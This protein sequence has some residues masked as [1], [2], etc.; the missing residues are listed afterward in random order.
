MTKTANTFTLPSAARTFYEA[1]AVAEDI[2]SQLEETAM[3]LIS[4]SR[5]STEET[6]K[7]GEHLERA[8]G[9]LPERTL[10]KWAVE[11]CGYT[12][13]HV[14]TQR[15]V[16]RNLAR[17]KDI[18]VELAV[19]PT[20]LGKLSAAEPEQIEQAIGF[21]AQHGRLRVADVAGIVAGAKQADDETRPE[22]GP[23]DA[24]GIEGLKT[25]IAIKVRDG[26][27]SFLEHIDEIR[28]HVA[29]ALMESRIVKKKLGEQIYP[30]AR[31]AR[32]ELES[33]VL[34]VR[35]DPNFAYNIWDTRFPSESRWNA[36]DALLHKIGGVETWPEMNGLRAWLE[37]EVLPLLEWA[38]AKTKDPVWPM[39]EKPTASPGATSLDEASS[40]AVDERRRQDEGG[41]ISAGPETGAVG[42]GA[43][44][45]LEAMLAPFGA[46]VTMEPSAASKEI[47][48][49][50]SIPSLADA[51]AESPKAFK[52]PAFLD[53]AKAA[54][55]SAEDGAVSAA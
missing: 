48:P 46:K 7:L 18:L 53:R 54:A 47:L 44:K 2:K 39:T 37:N 14:R 31:L 43:V 55:R 51:L 49:E 26:L 41:S 32:K 4:A 6:F 40:V 16:F 15:A 20:V 21:A 45:R 36:I 25:L 10:E 52:R 17:Y 19:G 33:L 23:Y 30:T 35:P 50:E 13:R 24:S 38:S 11:R 27:K 34:F 1:N 5:R 12:A 8:A 28:T 9:L 29:A 42:A 3:F 22:E